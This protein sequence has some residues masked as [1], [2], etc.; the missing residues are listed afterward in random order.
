LWIGHK[1]INAYL[2][3]I[4]KRSLGTARE[5]GGSSDTV[6]EC[7]TYIQQAQDNILKRCFVFR[8]KTSGHIT[9]KLVGYPVFA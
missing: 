7:V 8:V 2:E 5:V 6:S 9:K 4:P 1:E 3:T